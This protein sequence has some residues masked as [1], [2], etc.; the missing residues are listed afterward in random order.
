[1]YIILTLSPQSTTK[2][3]YADSFDP[4]ETPSYSEPLFDT[5]LRFDQL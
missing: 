2:V 1:L 4:D 3:Q 5:R